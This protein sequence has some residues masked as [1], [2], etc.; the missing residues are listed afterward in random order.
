MIGR[1]HGPPD[2]QLGRRGRQRTSFVAAGENGQSFMDVVNRFRQR[3]R[4]LF[5][6]F[7]GKQVRQGLFPF[8][9]GVGSSPRGQL[10]A[11]RPH[12][13]G[14]TGESEAF[15]SKFEQLRIGERGVV[16]LFV[17]PIFGQQPFDESLSVPLRDHANRSEG[18]VKPWNLT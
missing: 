14:Q 4:E 1:S 12:G 5:A 7:D 13:Q 6:L 11:K 15:L 8:G 10:G 9:L 17:H 3:C 2:V 18:G 16:L